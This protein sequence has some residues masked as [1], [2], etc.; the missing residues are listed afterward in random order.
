MFVQKRGALNRD[1]PKRT[2]LFQ[3]LSFFRGHL[4]FRGGAFCSSTL[5]YLFFFIPWKAWFFQLKKIPSK[6]HH[7]GSMI[8]YFNDGEKIR[9]KKMSQPPKRLKLK[10]S[11][12]PMFKNYKWI[13]VG[14]EPT[15]DP[16]YLSKMA[17]NQFAKTKFTS[18][19]TTYKVGSKH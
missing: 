17:R 3:S 13:V 19:S 4:N 10:T 2:I 6:K 16:H 15:C 7:L 5:N 18:L 1:Y 8:T 9:N 12:V 14:M 11:E